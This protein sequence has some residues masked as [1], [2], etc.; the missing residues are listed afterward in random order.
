MAFV[1]TV[2]AEQLREALAIWHPHDPQRNDAMLEAIVDAARLIAFP[3]LEQS[4]ELV[5]RVGRVLWELNPH[6]AREYWQAVVREVLTA[7]VTP[8]TSGTSVKV[9]K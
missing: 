3:V 9:G 6:M 8:G 4:E 1:L 5:E 2:T 7:L